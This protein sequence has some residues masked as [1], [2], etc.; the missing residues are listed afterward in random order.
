MTLELFVTDSGLIANEIAP[1]V[2]NSG[3]W[4]IE[5]AVCS[6]FENHMRAVTGLPL[7]STDI[8]KP[9]VMLN[10][11]GKY[12]NLQDVLAIDGVHFHHYHKDERD[13]RKIGHITIMCDELE[14]TVLKVEQLLK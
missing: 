3:H 14:E 11:I 12:P 5:G 9:S 13:G 1:R 4:S 2:H 7:G 8:I 6:Q 10:V